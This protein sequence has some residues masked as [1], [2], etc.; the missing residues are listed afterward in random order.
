V[1]Q[2]CRASREERQTRLSQHL[3]CV[4]FS[5]AVGRNESH[6]LDTHTHTYRKRGPSVRLTAALATKVTGLGC[7]Q[8][9]RPSTSS[10]LRCCCHTEHAHALGPSDSLA[11]VCGDT[12]AREEPG[13]G[14]R[15]RKEKIRAIENAAGRMRLIVCCDAIKLSLLRE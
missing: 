6:W 5:T 13:R 14:E 11:L 2:Y 4:S 12:R 7:W 10:A 1:C 15:E 9:Y 8:F 3:H